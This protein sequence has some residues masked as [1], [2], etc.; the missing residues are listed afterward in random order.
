[1]AI[2]TASLAF[3]AIH[4][5]DI[6]FLFYLCLN[7]KQGYQMKETLSITHTLE[8]TDVDPKTI[9]EIDSIEPGTAESAS[10]QRLREAGDRVR[11]L[12]DEHDKRKNQ[13]AALATY[14]TPFV[15][16]AP[17]P[18]AEM[19][20]VQPE[21]EDSPEREEEKA[22]TLRKIGDKALRFMER[23]GQGK[24]A[25]LLEAWGIIPVI[26]TRHKQRGLNFS[27]WV[28]RKYVKAQA[29]RK[30]REER[31]AVG[32]LSA[33]QN[34]QLSDEEPDDTETVTTGSPEAPRAETPAQHER[35]EAH[36][37][38]EAASED[39]EERRERRP[40]RER[41]AEARQRLSRLRGRIGGSAMKLL[42]KAGAF[43]GK[44]RR[45]SAE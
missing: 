12:L 21:H 40:M 2:R 20:A 26:G 38:A 30:N 13:E 31:M 36:A 29:A 27:A 34:D 9:E 23:R 19:P 45:R 7:E 39:R 33:E 16:E 6:D 25:K 17:A 4:D 32:F 37:A 11:A 35:S 1:M 22:S 44:L 14:E 15:P 41:T 10:Q 24:T 28:A 3:C 5:I 43:A 8:T 42:K 18:T